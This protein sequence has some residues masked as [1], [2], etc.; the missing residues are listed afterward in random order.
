MGYRVVKMML[1]L[2]E[3]DREIG[4]DD[5]KSGDGWG[6]V[7][8]LRGGGWWLVT[9]AGTGGLYVVR[10]RINRCKTINFLCLQCCNYHTTLKNESI[11]YSSMDC[12]D[13]RER[14]SYTCTRCISHTGYLGQG[15]YKKTNLGY[16]EE[17]RNNVSYS[18]NYPNLYHN[19][20]PTPNNSKYFICFSVLNKIVYI[21]TWDKLK[22]CELSSLLSFI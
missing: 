21:I 16:K 19:L 20:W 13:C 2:R 18:N 4:N 7:A 14:R 22:E 1:G 3:R 12:I 15:K 9:V 5:G 11:C 8:C 6:Q 10:T 17:I